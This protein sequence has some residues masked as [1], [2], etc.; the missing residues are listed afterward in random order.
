MTLPNVPRFIHASIEIFLCGWHW[1]AP[2]FLVDRELSNDS[3]QRKIGAGKS[4]DKIRGNFHR[5]NR[6]EWFCPFAN[7]GHDAAAL[8]RQA[9]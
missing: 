7:C 8:A 6:S 1:I 2:N 5:I 3:L 9:A 4:S